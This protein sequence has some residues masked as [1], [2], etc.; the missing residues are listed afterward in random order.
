MSPKTIFLIATRLFGLVFL[1][2][3]IP[4]SITAINFMRQYQS[5]SA[6]SRFDDMMMQ[7]YMPVLAQALLGILLILL[8]PIFAFGF[9]E[10]ERFETKIN[11]Y[12]MTVVGFR[13]AGFF[14]ACQKLA[15]LLK[16]FSNQKGDT[17][18]SIVPNV[19]G[20]LAFL[21][22]AFF[23]PQIAKLLPGSQTTHSVEPEETLPPI[24]S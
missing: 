12:G 15:D 3:A 20:I 19:V 18:T 13:V 2:L 17:P 5:Q 23:A 7:L 24:S 11:A 16:F 1:I 22:L 9:P 21:A 8:G 4:S 14:F 10:Q 6:P